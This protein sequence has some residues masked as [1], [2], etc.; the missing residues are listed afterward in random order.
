MHGCFWHGHEHCPDFR[1]PK[2]R[3]EGWQ[4]KISGNRSRDKRVE[5]KLRAMGWHDIT[6][7]ACALKN[8]HAK[9]WLESRIP[10]LVGGGKVGPM[11]AEVGRFLGLAHSGERV[12]I[13]Y[14]VGQRHVREMVRSPSPDVIERMILVLPGTDPIALGIDGDHVKITKDGNRAVVQIPDGA[15]P[16]LLIEASSEMLGICFFT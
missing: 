14:K 10:S 16:H 11:P 15:M 5:S 2:S 4:A 8:I 9:M 3:R 13:E 7:W 6:I 1:V 12:V